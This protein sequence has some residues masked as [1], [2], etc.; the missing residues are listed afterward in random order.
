MKHCSLP[1]S[2]MKYPIWL[3]E[4]PLYKSELLHHFHYV[5]FIAPA[6][7]Y[8]DIIMLIVEIFNFICLYY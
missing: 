3:V 2:Q 7:Y 5:S 8:V 6:A 1:A 4:M